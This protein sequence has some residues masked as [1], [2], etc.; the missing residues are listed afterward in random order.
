M[1]TYEAFPRRARPSRGLGLPAAGSPSAALALAI[2]DDPRLAHQLGLRAAVP[3]GGVLSAPQVTLVRPT[4][5][6]GPGGYIDFSIIAEIT[7]TC[8]IAMGQGTMRHR[9]GATLILDATGTPAMI[10]SQR[11]D[12]GHRL[13]AE[14]DYQRKALSR[15]QMVI[16]HG[17]LVPEP[18]HRRAICA[19]HAG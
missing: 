18:G 14:A 11:I 5:R 9:G 8:E 7:Q 3:G 10:V 15:G 19:P 13:E 17:R 12:N 2:D 4:L 6:V 16:R 1:A